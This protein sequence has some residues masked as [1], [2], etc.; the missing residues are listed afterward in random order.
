MSIKEELSA[1]ILATVSEGNT[2]QKAVK[3]L[4]SRGGVEDKKRE[5]NKQKSIVESRARYEAKRKLYKQTKTEELKQSAQSLEPIELF[6]K[7][8]ILLDL[9]TRVCKL[10]SWAP[11]EHGT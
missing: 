7:K 6:S 11:A 1:R 4:R 9:S 2:V 3:I 10:G 8:I 5:H